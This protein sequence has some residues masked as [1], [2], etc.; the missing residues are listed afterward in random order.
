M[1]DLPKSPETAPE[2]GHVI[3][4]RTPTP[5]SGPASPGQDPVD[6][7]TP[8]GLPVPEAEMETEE[9]AQNEDFS[10]E[11][12]VEI[13]AEAKESLWAPS[14]D[15]GEGKGPL[16][17]EG[18]RSGEPATDASETTSRNDQKS[19]IAAQ[20]DDEAPAEVTE[21]TQEAATAEEAETDP[22]VEPS[23]EAA[24]QEASQEASQTTTELFGALPPGVSLR[25]LPL[26]IPLANTEYIS[27]L[28]SYESNLY[29]GTSRGRVLHY[30]LFEDAEEYILILERAVNGSE[31]APIRKIVTL[32]DLEMCMFLQNKTT[33]AF[34]LPELSPLRTGKLKDVE[35]LLLLSQGKLGSS[36][37]KNDKLLI[38]TSSKIRVV[39]MLKDSAKLLR[40][41]N[42]AGALTGL[43]SASGTLANY[44]NICIVAGATRY[45]VVDMQQTRKIPLFDYNPTGEARIAPLIA[46]FRAAADGTT[47]E[48]YLLPICSDDS[49]S[50]AM[51]INSSGDVTRGTLTWIDR[52]YPRLGV[53]IDWPFAYGIFSRKDTHPVFLVSSLETLEVVASIPCSQLFKENVDW[54]HC[55]LTNV[56]TG[57]KVVDRELLEMLSVVSPDGKRLSVSNQFQ[58]A[59]S[60]FSDGHRLEYIEKEQEL[61]RLIREALTCAPNDAKF[62]EI[63]AF[64]Q[65]QTDVFG[66]SMYFALLYFKQD[67]LRIKDLISGQHDSPKKIDPRLF[68]YFCGLGEAE[69]EDFGLQKCLRQLKLRANHEENRELRVWIIKEV[70]S[71]GEH[72]S[73]TVRS[74]FRKLMYL[75]CCSTSADY[76]LVV[77]SEKLL[78]QGENAINDSIMAYLEEKKHS[79]VLIRIY[80]LKQE[81]GNAFQDWVTKIIDLGLESLAERRSEDQS[82]DDKLLVK[83]IFDQLQDHADSE[84]F[85]TKKLLRLLQLSPETGLGLLKQHKGGKFKSTHKFIFDELSKSYELGPQFAS[86]KIEYAEQSFLEK[87]TNTVNYQ[88]A[89]ELL[90]EYFDYFKAAPIDIELENLNILF[91]TFQIENRCRDLSWPK[92]SWCDFV[93]VNGPKSGLE[94]FFKMY[95]KA[96]ELVV[97]CRLGEIPVNASFTNDALNYF[98]RSTDVA[99]LIEIADFTSAEW[100]SV[101]GTFKLPKEP[102]LSE[103]LLA[104]GK[105]TYQI[106]P[107][108]VVSQNLAN[109]VLHYLEIEDELFRN[110]ALLALINR[111]GRTYF[112]VAEVLQMLP[113]KLP[114]MYIEGFL[115]LKLLSL[116]DCRREAA[117]K[118]TLVKL[119]SKLSSDV[120]KHFES[121]RV[122]DAEVAP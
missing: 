99:Y 101:H 25:A 103:P 1:V 114:L 97:I 56:E 4:D 2:E 51:F 75:E 28:G 27:C 69:W 30:Y 88:A 82:E 100:S 49:T 52:G 16:L 8:I 113:E 10:P 112:G 32:P 47:H 108:A 111:Q 33:F 116:E 72:Y 21:K 55:R 70:H 91:Q 17:V 86:L 41:I 54:A 119:N 107:P 42:Y 35:D 29:L 50:M 53:A 48:E 20:N 78:W 15:S 40:D 80:L 120:L 45:D 98:N 66:R 79:D 67:F 102:Y 23:P 34:S 39:Q 31:I 6:P 11:N 57:V 26:E 12:S 96:Y 89:K 64:F 84:E 36:K 94:E 73:E 65:A 44:S 60:V 63:L 13:A 77:E 9:A 5:Q 76:T 105:I 83:L 85:Y 46:P 93:R 19:P 121:L 58:S 81:I 38:F 22:K 7:A 68:L 61:T 104:S 109:V 92:L 37:N 106:L 117:L 3:P 122:F 43:S 71:N 59:N 14:L 18:L 118:K 87:S 95:I 24:S 90:D 74:Q 115:V 62:P 110:T